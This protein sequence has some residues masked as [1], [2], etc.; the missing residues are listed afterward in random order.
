MEK[1]LLISGPISVEMEHFRAALRSSLHSDNPLLTH[2]VSHIL[3]KSGKMMRP[4]LTLLS[5]KLLGEVNPATHHA[6]ISLEL[7][8]NASL[9][10]DDVVDESDQRR[11]Q[12]SVNALFNN[13]VAVLS[14]DYLLATSLVQVAA[15]HHLEIIA[16]VARLGQDLA[17]GELL[18]LVNVSND[19]FSDEIYYRVIK[20]K[21]AVLFSA[22]TQA[23]ALSVDASAEDVERMRLFGEYIGICFQ[24][25]DDIFDYYV[26]EEIGKPT[27]NDMKE[28][29]LTL[30]V[31]YALNSTRDEVAV[32]WAI[33][34]KHGT[35]S[36][37]E[38]AQLVEFTKQHGGVEY[39]EQTMEQWKAKAIELLSVYPDG[40]VKTALLA[41][42][43]CVIK[44]SR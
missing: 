1:T 30:P 26:N 6:A 35:A 22:C 4:M 13:K 44:R 37:E 18:Q 14:G 31:L 12:V 2:V 21:T 16:L 17:D 39:A 11:G 10:H 15:T 25:R 40:E 9:V 41:Y 3:Q 32:S 29:K 24:I 7:L 28:G 33:K 20:K 5:A 38:I 19:T 8:H 34:V 43:D 23:G 36:E 27:G 42:L